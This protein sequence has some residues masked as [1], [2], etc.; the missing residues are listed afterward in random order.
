[1]CSMTSLYLLL[2]LSYRAHAAITTQSSIDAIYSG[3]YAIAATSSSSSVVCSGSNRVVCYVTNGVAN[4]QPADYV[5][6]PLE[7]AAD[8]SPADTRFTSLSSSMMLLCGSKSTTSWCTTLTV[9]GSTVT[10]NLGPK[11]YNWTTVDWRSVSISATSSTSAVLCALYNGGR[12]LHCLS[13]AVSASGDINPGP[14][15]KIDSASARVVALV[16]LSSTKAVVC[17]TD[18]NTM[19]LRCAE[20]TISG[21]TITAAKSKPRNDQGQITIYS[22]A[23]TKLT[24]TSLVVCYLWA[25]PVLDDKQVLC[26]H[27]SISPLTLGKSYAMSTGEGGNKV[28][29]ASLGTGKDIVVCYGPGPFSEQKGSSDEC[30]DLGE[31]TAK[32]CKV[33][34]TWKSPGVG[35]SSTPIEIAVNSPT[36]VMLAC[37]LRGKEG[38]EVLSVS[39]SERTADCTVHT[40]GTYC[41]PEDSSCTNADPSAPNAGSTSSGE[42]GSSNTGGSAGV[43]ASGSDARERISFFSFA[44]TLI[45]LMVTSIL[46]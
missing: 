4:P 39:S 28:S 31:F 21:A 44:S 26:N 32:T 24:D 42:G 11:I 36:K 29:V 41:D 15:T 14:L 23:A 19:H 30:K 2:L 43:V 16:G 10:P 12:G 34:S 46:S 25:K 8:E 40:A 38:V 13:M 9:S 3:T 7:G 5:Q 33:G 27:M 22:I 20:L 17:Y 18:V 6:V 1:M 37:G 35:Y 45:V